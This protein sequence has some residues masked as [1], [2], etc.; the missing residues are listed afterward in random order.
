MFWFVLAIIVLLVAQLC[1]LI[2]LVRL[3]LHS[4][5]YQV[6]LEKKLDDI[7]QSNRT[8]RVTPPFEAANKTKSV[9]TSSRRVVTRKSPDQIRNENYDQIKK[10]AEYGSY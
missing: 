4:H 2:V 10:G 6:V 8:G 1:A 3:Q 9:N 7:K 5:D